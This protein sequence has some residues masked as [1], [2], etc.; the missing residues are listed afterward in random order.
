[1][2]LLASI[3]GLG[4][5]YGGRADLLLER[6][7]NF[8]RDREQAEQEL[9]AM[10]AETRLS[11]WI[12][13]LLPVGVGAFLIMTN[14]GYF[15]GMWNDGTGRILIFSAA[16]PAA[17]R[18]GPVLPAG[19][20][21]M[22]LTPNL[23][24]IFEPVAARRSACWSAPA[25]WW[26]PNCGARAAARSSAARSARWLPR[27]TNRAKAVDDPPRRKKPTRRR[28]PTSNCRSTGS[29]P[30]G[31]RAGGGR[32]PQPH[33]PVRP[34]RRS[35]RSS[36]SW[37]RASCSRVLL[38]FLAY[39]GWAKDMY[40]AP[41]SWCWHGVLHRLHGTQVGARPDRRRPARTREP[42]AAAVHRPAALLQGVGLSLD[43]SLQIMA[44]DFSHVL[45]VLGY[46]L[47]LANN[48]YSRG[49]TREHSLHRLATLHKN[50]N[51]RG[52]VS[53]LV[54]V[55]KHGG[56]VQEPLRVFSDRLRETGA[57]K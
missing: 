46:E 29:T 14:P 49:R 37:S 52:L 20:T 18:C 57:R 23:L 21:G 47:T 19:E 28:M 35:A 6:V 43:Q 48:Q 45:R 17:V 2:F 25:R 22:T 36:C 10:S 4:V 32:R 5:R 11:A 12:L 38:P 24:A 40:S 44:T 30:A 3:L 1:M 26:R 39:V 7:G 54:Q 8:M 16:G 55:D 33:R 41:W 42:G 56:A 34:C 51:L 27:P 53:L 15:M 13:G 50:E 31:P 9:V